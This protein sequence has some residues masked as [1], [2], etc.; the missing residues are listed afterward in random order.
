MGSKIPIDYVPPGAT[1]RQRIARRSPSTGLPR[2]D[3]PRSDPSLPGRDGEEVGGSS[4]AQTASQASA[5]WSTTTSEVGDV[6]RSTAIEIAL[7][8]SQRALASEQTTVA[9]RARQLQRE[10]DIVA[11]FRRSASAVA[12]ACGTKEL[13]L[14]AKKKK[15]LKARRVSDHEHVKTQD[16]TDLLASL[17]ALLQVYGD[18]P[19]QEE[20]V[21]GRRAAE[22]PRRDRRDDDPSKR[23]RSHAAFSSSSSSTKLSSSSSTSS[24]LGPSTPQSPPSSSSEASGDLTSEEDEVIPPRRR[25]EPRPAKRWEVNDRRLA[26]QAPSRRYRRLLSYMTYFLDDTQLA[27]SRRQVRQANKLRKYLE[28]PFEGERPFTGKDQLGIFELLST[29]KRACDAA[30]ASHVQAFS[31]L[32]F[33]LSGAAKQSFISA[34]SRDKR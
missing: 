19:V 31:L 22:G 10:K 23:S 16:P 15:K 8:E 34:V 6:D 14:H 2:K 11:Q 29:F 25:R 20:P 1:R 27:F 4:R 33:R 17:Q 24:T 18:R 32:S 12:S 5:L 9:N 3:P 26:V 7:G 30:R 13:P 28:G 21:R